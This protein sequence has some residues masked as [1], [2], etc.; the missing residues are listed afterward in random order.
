MGL[1]VSGNATTVS[2]TQTFIGTVAT[3]ATA[4]PLTGDSTT[5]ALNDTFGTQ[6][7]AHRGNTAAT[8][9]GEHTIELTVGIIAT[10]DTGVYKNA[11]LYPHPQGRIGTVQIQWEGATAGGPTDTITMLLTG[12]SINSE[13]N[14]IIDGEITFSAQ[15]EITTGAVA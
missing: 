4:I 7:A 13:V 11:G 9:P 5:I 1:P 3:P 8:V 6:S 12:R 2:F 14:G 10:S 15:S